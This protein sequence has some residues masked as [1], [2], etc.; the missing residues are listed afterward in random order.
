[1]IQKHEVIELFLSACPSYKERWLHFVSETY[2]DSE[3]HLPYI[4]VSDFA[5]H[6]DE[7]YQQQK[8]TEFPMI[9]EVLEM[10]H[11][12]GDDYVKEL[13]TIGFLESL[14]GCEIS[15]SI[16]CFLMPIS[17]KWWIS[18][19]KFMSGESRYVGEDQ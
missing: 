11:I 19:N 1:M 7:L 16:E 3:E 9:F 14:L 5:Q 12:N 18:L 6:V 17:L 4:D 13:A 10:L 15:S 8:L 2:D